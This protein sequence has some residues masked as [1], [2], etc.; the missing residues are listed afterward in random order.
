MAI[1]TA[2]R[3][4]SAWRRRSPSPKYIEKN[5]VPGSVMVFGTP[6]EEMMPPNAKVEMFKAGVFNGM[7]I[8]VRS[9]STSATVAPRGRIRNLL[10]EYRRRE[11]HFQRRAVASDDAVGR[12]QRARSR[13]PTVQ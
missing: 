10:P 8:L 5:H 9:H 7:D 2:R 1:S 13:D 6:G 4:R 11:I 12:T 3:A